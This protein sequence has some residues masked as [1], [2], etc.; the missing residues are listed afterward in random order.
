[1]T[2]LSGDVRSRLHP[3][4]TQLVTPPASAFSPIQKFDDAP[5]AGT[6]GSESISIN[7]SIPV[8][9][10]SAIDPSR[11]AYEFASTDGKQ[12]RSTTSAGAPS[13]PLKTNLCSLIGYPPL[14]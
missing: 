14:L 10:G 3:I 4:C 13:N 5:P 9:R 12:V 6:V 8:K 7:A 11:P 2:G 1:M